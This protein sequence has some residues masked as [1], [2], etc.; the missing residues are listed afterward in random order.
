M[1]QPRSSLVRLCLSFIAAATL[2]AVLAACG[3]GIDGGSDD[4]GPK[5]VSTVHA[6]PIEGSATIS[7]WPL[8]ID[9]NTIKEFNQKYG[10]KLN[11]VEDVND[12]DGFF[13]KMQPLLAA[14]KSGGRSGMIFAD[15]LAEK[16]WNLGYLQ[17]IDPD[18]MKT[19]RKNII[20]SLEHRD[21][22]PDMEYSIPWQAGMAGLIV[23]KKKAPDVHSINDLFDPKYKGKVG[24]VTDVRNTLPLVMLADGVDPKT[25]SRQD[26]MDA[27]DKLQ[28]QVDS[29][30]IR[31]FWGNDYASE[32]ASGNLIA[33]IGWSGDV[34]MLQEDNPDLEWRMP[35]DGCVLFT[36]NFVVPVGAP[37]PQLALGF[38]NYVYEPKN[39]AQITDYVGYISPV[40]GV[41]EILKKQGSPV[42]EDPLAFPS[43]EFLSKCVWETVLKEKDEVPVNQAFQQLIHG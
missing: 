12:S 20:P 16:M 8:Y 40:K 6:G 33:G 10:V 34:G 36:D 21:F 28:E 35:T 30:Q 39:A 19:V 43:E 14:G 4:S 18:A 13:G 32:Y 38:M 24:M 7:N 26:W 11:Y 5:D 27:I 23:N 42:A 9:A 22:D 15:F 29:G 37:N 2:V 3:N 17:K 31:G 1:V 41:Q 25:A